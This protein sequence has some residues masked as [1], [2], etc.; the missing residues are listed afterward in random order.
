[1]ARRL[2]DV[3][4]LKESEPLWKIGRGFVVRVIVPLTVGEILDEHFGHKLA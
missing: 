3:S 4:G 1:M 2:H